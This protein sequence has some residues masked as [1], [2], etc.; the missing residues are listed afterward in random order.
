MVGR[1][2]ELA[3]VRAAVADRGCVVAG[4][5]GVGKSRLAR[6]AVGDRPAIEVLA[7]QSASAVPYGAFAHLFQTGVHGPTDIIPAFI[8]RLA[9]EYPGSAPV[10]LVDDGHLLDQASAALVLALATTG[11]AR[12]LV[13]V[14]TP[15]SVPDA[16]AALWKERGLARLDLQSLGRLDVGELVRAELGGPVDQRA[17][18]R[19][20]DL[21]LG[22][23]LYV[24]ELLH[25]AR[26]TGTLALVDGAW[27][28][29]EELL[30][31][32]RLSVLIRRHI[33]TV[34]EGARQALESV[35][36]VE[37]V[38]LA[39][40]A[41]LTSDDAVEEL[42][43]EGLIRVGADASAE[44]TVAHPLY[45]EVV[46]AGVGRATGMRIRR[47]AAAALQSA[48]ADPLRIAVLLLDAGAA[49]PRLFVEASGMALRRGGMRLAL[50]LAEGA[51]ESLDAALAVAG[52]LIALGRF[53]E[54]EPVLAPYEAL[55]SGAE[56]EVSV[57]Y[58]GQRCRALLRSSL[59]ESVRTDLLQR[60]QR[61]HTGPEWEALIGHE[62]GWTAFFAGRYTEALDWVD[63]FVDDE[64]VS[65]GRR[66]F[67]SALGINVR[68]RLGRFD[69]CRAEAERAKRLAAAMAS[70]PSELRVALMF[71]ELLPAIRVG[72]D[73]AGTEALLRA[74]ETAALATGDDTLRTAVSMLSGV[75]AMRRG[76][77][78]DAVSYLDEAA[79]ALTEA[80]P[81]NNALFAAICRAEA[82][83]YMGDV[84]RAQA[85]LDE[86]ERLAAEQPRSAW[87]QATFIETVRALVE[88]AA[89][90]T[91]AAV[92]RLLAVVDGDYRD[93]QG[94][95]VA[96]CEA[97]R[98][99]ADP[100]HVARLLGSLLTGAQD[101]VA[102]MVLEHADALARDD[103]SA[104]MSIAERF[105]D[106]GCDLLAAEAAARAARAFAAAGRTASSRHAASLAATYAAPCGPVFS[107]AL[108]LRPDTPELTARER[109]IAVLAARGQK[110]KEIAEKLFLS[111]RT[112]ESHLLSA[113]QKL[114]VA[115]R[116]GL[117][118]V[119]DH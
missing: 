111:V 22:N 117:P 58:L 99:G 27:H 66:F 15:E 110:N 119:I 86:I 5:A 29:H 10:A 64:R 74:S 53:D 61:W 115:N 49:E 13:T 87:R 4:V 19:I 67:L 73:L 55:A 84:D 56:L 25:D 89:G 12:P 83:A 91:S 70:R 109:E 93:L 107:W 8:H 43:R 68:G 39:V 69:D 95:I 32:D 60:A 106:L 3:F 14:R 41:E 97:L 112:V 65:L 26:Q 80:D 47:R 118:A 105:H 82:F 2:E 98:F 34:S 36:V 52:A 35:A 24:R 48:A 72:H 79:D 78:T 11:A 96:L 104:Q 103:A 75:L 50:R 44:V 16:I 20:A 85:Q 63:A 62:N 31:F 59:P 33:E 40:L 90:Q 101:D 28:W 77:A 51:G 23:P 54:V 81:V 6:E 114:G 113:C 17:V 46:A 57:N 18:T 76:H 108:Q 100:A 38:P 71:S 7:T 1:G 30:A 21:S 88:G 92:S 9:D 116:H 42:E 37:Q 45:G 94:E 102:T